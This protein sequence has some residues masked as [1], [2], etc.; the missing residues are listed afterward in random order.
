M[1][2]ENK[3]EICVQSFLN[4]YKEQHKGNYIHQRADTHFPDLKGDLNWDFVAYKRDNPKEWIGIEVKELLRLKEIPIQLEFWQRLCSELTK[5]LKGTGIQGEFLI[6]L[7]PPFNLRSKKRSEFKEAFI[8]VLCEKA[9]NMKINQII[10]I[11]PNIAARFANWPR[12][13]SDA[14]DEYDKWGTS[15]PSKLQIEKISDSGCKVSVV[16]SPLITGDVVEEHKEIFNEVFKLKNDA[17]PANTQLKL[18]KEKGA[19][20]TILLLCCNAFVEETLIKNELQI[21]DRHLI[22][23]IDCIYLVDMGSEGEVVKT[24]PN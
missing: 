1:D 10:D 7:P 19:T 13:K 2:K 14:F 6:I 20:K 8:A 11:S 3:E 12:E 15:R 9:P 16:T 18:A 24:Y 23:D 5:D 17:I 22:P 21:F 4:W